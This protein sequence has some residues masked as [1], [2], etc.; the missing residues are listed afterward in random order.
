[1]SDK[2]KA[3]FNIHCLSWLYIDVS[4]NLIIYENLGYITESISV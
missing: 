3:L 1:M 4:I 2:K